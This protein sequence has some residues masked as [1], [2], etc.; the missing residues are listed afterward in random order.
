MKKFKFCI[1]QYSYKTNET[2]DVSFI[3]PM[4]RRKLS[5]LDKA[6]L[7]ALNEV[8][9][10]NNVKLIFASQYG[11][12][13]R[14]KKLVTQY[15]CENEVS[16]ATFSSSVHNAAI[17]Q[18][19]L[20]KKITQSY[21]SISAEENTFSVGLIEAVLSAQNTDILYCYCDSNVTTDSFACIIS[22]NLNND[23]QQFELDIQEKPLN[24]KCKNELQDFL[25]TI[26]LQ[27][28]FISK[29]GLF[30]ITKG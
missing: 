30:K 18:F 10:S 23:G 3:A 20:L 17:G 26:E 24:S 19:S 22:T 27:T 25:K 6:T 15:V 29:N 12:L 4:A 21:N 1:K 8:F 11:E 14:L 7:S 13:D 9:E 16:P 5:T 28:D 2:M